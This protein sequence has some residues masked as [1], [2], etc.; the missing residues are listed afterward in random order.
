MSIVPP[1]LPPPPTPGPDGAQ[2]LSERELQ[3][4]AKLGADLEA[5]D[6][7]LGTQLSRTGKEGERQPHQ[8]TVDRSVQTAAVLVICW[9]ILPSSWMGVLTFLALTIGL[10]LLLLLSSRRG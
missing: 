5:S 9:L 1:P 4:L 2:P 6:P 3:I 8:R 7:G 10:P